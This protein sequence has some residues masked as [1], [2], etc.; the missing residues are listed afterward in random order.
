MQINLNLIPEEFVEE[1]QLRTIERKDKAL[2]EVMKV[3][4]GLKET[5]KQGPTRSDHF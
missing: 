2:A 4:Y 1:Y 5:G 3:M